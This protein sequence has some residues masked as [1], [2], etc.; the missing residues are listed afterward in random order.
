MN[1]SVEFLFEM[2]NIMAMVEV[3]GLYKSRYSS[4]ETT[5]I[6]RTRSSIQLCE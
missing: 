3:N 6:V 2:W 5:M 4:G 1:I